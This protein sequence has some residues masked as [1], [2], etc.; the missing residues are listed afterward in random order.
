[1]TWESLGTIATVVAAVAAVV[2]IWLQNK[3]FKAT[4]TADLAM[5][6]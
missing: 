2:A 1:M 3:S 5:K 4:L 6:L